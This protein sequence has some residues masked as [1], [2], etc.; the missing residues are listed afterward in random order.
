[1]RV[2][3]TLIELLVVIAIIAILAAL[4]LPALNKARERGQDIRCKANLKQ[5]GSATAVYVQDFKNFCP[6]YYTWESQW[7]F[8]FSKLNYLSGTGYVSNT[9]GGGTPWNKP[10]GIL[11]CPSA[12][13]LLTWAWDK[14]YRM[15]HY[16]INGY[17]INQ[18]DASTGACASNGGV[19][20]KAPYGL[21]F[22][23]GIMMFMDNN[24]ENGVS[25]TGTEP[26]PFFIDSSTCLYAGGVKIG[27]SSAAPPGIGLRHGGGK[28]VNVCYWDGHVGSV[29]PRGGKNGRQNYYNNSSSRFFSMQGIF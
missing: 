18:F 28:A 25:G 12:P 4:L 11:N 22:I 10:Q 3:F 13:P 6:V 21:S 14:G 17:T 29:L 16:A 15:T 5:L 19:P 9:E 7:L 20:R 27:D 24:R 8:T 23:S 26:S 2:R 1:M